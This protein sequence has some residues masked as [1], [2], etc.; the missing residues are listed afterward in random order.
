ME[1]KM[2]ATGLR[3]GK[4]MKSTMLFGF[5]NGQQHEHLHKATVA[6]RVR[7]KWEGKEH[8]S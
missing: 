3:N 1:K 5:T 7:G 8:G 4:K 6:C 2:E